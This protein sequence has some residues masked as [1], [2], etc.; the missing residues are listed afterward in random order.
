MIAR[1]LILGLVLEENIVSRITFHLLEALQANLKKILR[2]FFGEVHYSG[3]VE[4]KC[5]CDGFYG[6]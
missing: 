4:G 6:L 1:V 2:I 3:N 5:C